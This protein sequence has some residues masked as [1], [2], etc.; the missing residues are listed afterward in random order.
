M[1]E[2]GEPLSQRRSLQSP[3]SI[4]FISMIR[5]C[6]PGI[7]TV[8]DHCNFLAVFLSQNVVQQGSFAR[9]QITWI[10]MSAQFYF[11]PVLFFDTCNKGNGNSRRRF[12]L[13][14]GSLLGHLRDIDQLRRRIIVLIVGQHG[15]TDFKRCRT[16]ETSRSSAKQNSGRRCG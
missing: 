12:L 6:H 3:N 10:V 15:F 4:D 9:T 7:R 1:L 2:R 13:Y 5:K 11:S 14:R 8:H 16:R